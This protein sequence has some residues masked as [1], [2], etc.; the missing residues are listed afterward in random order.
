MAHAPLPCFQ[1]V[2]RRTTSR[3]TCSNSPL[4][5]LKS[6]ASKSII[7]TKAATTETGALRAS[8]SHRAT[9]SHFLAYCAQKTRA[10]ALPTSPF[11]RFDTNYTTH[12]TPVRGQFFPIQF[13][14]HDQMFPRNFITQRLFTDVSK[15]PCFLLKQITYATKKMS[16]R[17]FRLP[18]KIMADAA[19]I[20]PKNGE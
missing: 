4:N 1:D 3:W 19:P 20:T 11:E 12:T 5:S 18:L 13:S 9:H 14:A 17:D 10:P 2:F 16:C 6:L 8:A 15:L 7:S